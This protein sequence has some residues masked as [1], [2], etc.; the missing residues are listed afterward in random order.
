MA[1]ILAVDDS[2]SMRQLLVATL[3]DAGHQVTQASDGVEGLAAARA[4]SFDLILSDINM[5]NMDG[6]TLLRHLRS[7]PALKTCPILILTTEMDPDLRRR[8]REA[9]AT[10]WIVKPFNPEQLLATIR[11]VAVSQRRA[12]VG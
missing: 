1:S 2:K 6:L 3:V 9:G 5:P 7:L 8:A 11:R 4:Q 10:G 12:G